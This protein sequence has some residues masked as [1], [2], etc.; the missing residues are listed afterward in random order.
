MAKPGVGFKK[1]THPEYCIHC[2]GKL[3]IHKKK[4]PLTKELQESLAQ[5]VYCPLCG[6]AVN[7]DHVC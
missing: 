5:K 2:G 7:G 6:K 1:G 4:C 3:H